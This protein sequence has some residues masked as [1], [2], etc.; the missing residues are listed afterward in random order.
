MLD[1][2]HISMAM[3]LPFGLMENKSTQTVC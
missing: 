3:F 2:S 1:S